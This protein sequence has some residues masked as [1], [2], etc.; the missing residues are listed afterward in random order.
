MC[1]WCEQFAIGHQD[2]P[3]S[4][5]AGLS[6]ITRFAPRCLWV[7]CGGNVAPAPV[8]SM[9]LEVPSRDQCALNVRPQ[10]FMELT[11]VND[12]KAEF[13]I[14][15]GARVNCKRSNGGEVDR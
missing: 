9:H 2:P 10:P 7:N 5:V 11:T 6:A 8:Y 13:C 1:S 14:L 4:D 12:R 3:V 15:L